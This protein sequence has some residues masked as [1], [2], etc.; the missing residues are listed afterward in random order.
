MKKIFKLLQ[1]SSISQKIIA[2]FI[3][4]YVLFI[5]MGLI[6]LSTLNQGSKSIQEVGQVINPSIDRLEKFRLLVTQSQAYTFSWIYETAE[7]RLQD[8][9][10]FRKIHEEL[11]EFKDQLINLSKNWE[12]K[13]LIKQLDSTI[14]RFE[15]TKKAQ[16]EIMDV[17][18]LP[19]DYISVK[20]VEKASAI[21]NKIVLPEIDIILNNLTQIIAQK[22]QERENT[23][24]NLLNSFN[25]LSNLVIIFEVSLV[26]LGFVVNWWTRRQ[27][28]R[29]IKYVNS[30]FVKLGQGEIPEDKHYNF[31]KDEIGEMAQSADKL[32]YSLKTT[33]SFAQSIGR[34]EYDAEYKP[35]SERDIL[36]N[37]LVEMRNNLAKVAEEER[38]RTWINEGLVQ[39]SEILKN[40]NEIKDLSEKIIASLVKYIK[41]NQGALFIVEEDEKNKKEDILEMSACYAWDIDK[42]YLQQT[43]YKGD[44]LVGQTWLE[45]AT[46]C[47]KDIPDGYVRITSGLGESNPNCIL[48]V[49]LKT[50]DKVY[51]VVEIASFNIFKDHE[52]NFVEKVAESIA[53]AIANVKSNQKNQVLLE[54][55]RKSADRMKAQEEE[56]RQ[57]M[58]MLQT[59]QEYMEQSQKESQEIENLFK[60]SFYLIETDKD[61][62]MI[63][64]NDFMLKKLNFVQ[65]ELKGLSIDHLFVDNQQANSIKEKLEKREK[66]KAKVQIKA[67]NNTYFAANVAAS[68]IENRNAQFEKYLFVID[69]IS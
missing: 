66:I 21:L 63:E 51:G 7:N 65:S 54:E 39:F 61:F 26:F 24:G 52:I 1:F 57:N 60:S 11:P 47:L 55:S 30:V 35:S 36:G 44:G 37:A 49:P 59:T 12:N 19:E 29:P 56:M 4:I 15:S 67:K 58:E 62:K 8:K 9:K 3:F 2:G 16:E 28:A 34:G 64:L 20:K 22:K 42:S 13:K 23:E 33:S 18:M 43:V 46:I 41:A 6:S 40:S 68:A 25:N 69:D 5:V 14:A 45:E 38:I 48:I 31:N 32:I 53:S 10:A 50:N 17:L 27:I